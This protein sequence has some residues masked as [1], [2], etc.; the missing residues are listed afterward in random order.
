MKSKLNPL[1][2]FWNLNF[3]G[4]PIGADRDPTKELFS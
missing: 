4:L 3:P 1:K 2:L